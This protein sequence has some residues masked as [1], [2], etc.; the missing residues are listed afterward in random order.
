MPICDTRLRSSFF[1]IVDVEPES[2]NLQKKSAPPP[3]CHNS[4]RIAPEPEVAAATPFVPTRRCS[5]KKA[6][7]K[8]GGGSFVCRLNQVWIKLR[9]AREMLLRDARERCSHSK[10]SCACLSCRCHRSIH[11]RHL[12]GT[13][14]EVRCEVRVFV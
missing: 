6:E 4:L 9:D 7:K 14:V 5:K 10:H 12:S 1:V 11:I 13:E 3:S 8:R 2:E